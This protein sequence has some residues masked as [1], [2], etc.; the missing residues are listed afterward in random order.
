[1]STVRCDNCDWTGPESQ[2]RPLEDLPKLGERLTP[3][4]QVPAG[5]CPEC[6][7]FAYLERIRD[8]RY[9]LWYFPEGVAPEERYVIQ[10]DPRDDASTAFGDPVDARDALRELTA[11][12]S[13]SEK[14]K[15]RIARIVAEV[16]E[17]E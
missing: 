2:V 8:T 6:E 15:Y 16:L 12:V 9:E 10:P 4:S 13:R 1:M 14:S 17:E 3:G 11:E 5:E 7:A